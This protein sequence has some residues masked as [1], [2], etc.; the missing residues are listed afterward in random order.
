MR[1][2]TIQYKNNP[3]HYGVIAIYEKNKFNIERN[4]LKRNT[5]PFTHYTN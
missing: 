1:I 3:C 2:I 5:R 4:S